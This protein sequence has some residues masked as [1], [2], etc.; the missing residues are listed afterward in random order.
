MSAGRVFVLVDELVAKD[1]L[2]PD[3]VMFHVRGGLDYL[4]ARHMPLLIARPCPQ[5]RSTLVDGSKILC[6]LAFSGRTP[7]NP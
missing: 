6:L 4:P 2:A 3:A 5:G 7:S 1:D